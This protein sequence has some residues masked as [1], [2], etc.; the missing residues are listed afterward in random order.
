MRVFI[1][2][3]LITCWI[4]LFCS[5]TVW[6]LHSTHPI[7]DWIG[8]CL[9]V[10]F[11]LLSAYRVQCNYQIPGAA[12]WAVGLWL[13]S[14]LLLVAYFEQRSSLLQNTLILSSTLFMVLTVPMQRVWRVLLNKKT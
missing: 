7:P 9:V 14:L 13:F 8:R 4:L 10:A 1:D 2:S 5:V 12:F 3:A 11:P 6:L